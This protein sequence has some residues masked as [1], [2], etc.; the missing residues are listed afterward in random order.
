MESM[1]MKKYATG[2]VCALLESSP[3]AV[4]FL[5]NDHLAE[6]CSVFYTLIEGITAD[7]FTA[8]ISNPPALSRS[9]QLDHIQSEH[10]S[11][12]NSKLIYS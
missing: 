7:H 1:V 9:T 11:H 12:F 8:L 3:L 6:I 5:S 2:A 4:S 10:M